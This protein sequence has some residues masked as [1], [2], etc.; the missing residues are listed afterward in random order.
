MTFSSRIWHLDIQLF[1]SL[2]TPHVGNLTVLHGRFL[3]I[4]SMK[5]A[6]K[7]VDASYPYGLGIGL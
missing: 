6:N 7:D 1:P 4:S 2:D 3:P 5:R